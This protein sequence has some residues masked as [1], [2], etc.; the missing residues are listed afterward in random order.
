VKRLVDTNVLSE[1]LKRKN[2]Q[3]MRKAASYLNQHGRWTFSLMTYYEIVRGLK[4]RSATTKLARFEALCQR[5]EILPV[6]RDLLVLA[7]DL[8]ASLKRAGRLIEDVD[9]LIA[10]TALHHG[11]PLATG[12][13][14]HFSRIPGLALDDWTKP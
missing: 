3:I 12:N 8:Y 1:V 9:L 14:A 2:A 6:T 7:A 13:T 4:A 10:A 5:Q 11:L